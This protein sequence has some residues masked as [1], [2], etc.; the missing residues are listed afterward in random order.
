MM[1]NLLLQQRNGQHYTLVFLAL[2]SFVPFVLHFSGHPIW[3]SILN[4]RFLP[5]AGSTDHSTRLIHNT[6]HCAQKMTFHLSY[7]EFYQIE[8]IHKMTEFLRC[9]LKEADWLELWLKIWPL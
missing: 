6:L 7:F 9:A 4:I 2:V 8:S 3:N 1:E 5:P